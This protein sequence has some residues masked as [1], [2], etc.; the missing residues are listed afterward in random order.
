MRIIVNNKIK[1]ITATNKT[2]E[3]EVLDIFNVEG[4]K[5]KDYILY[6][7]GEEIDKEDEQAYVSII[8]QKKGNYSLVEI[9]DEKEWKIVQKTIEESISAIK[10]DVAG[11]YALGFSSTVF[12]AATA[13]ARGATLRSRG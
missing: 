11:E 5:D 4:Y 7:L 8:K 2:L 13:L 9:T 12:P 1:V 10:D 6:S 3:I